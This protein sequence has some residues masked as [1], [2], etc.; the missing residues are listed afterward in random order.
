MDLHDYQ[1]V[2]E[3]YDAYLDVMYKDHDNYEILHRIKKNIQRFDISI[4]LIR[5]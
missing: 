1:D 4:I 3:N 5:D 2:A